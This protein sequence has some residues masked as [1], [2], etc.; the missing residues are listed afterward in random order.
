MTY[1][2]LTSINVCILK[3][4][5]VRV[6]RSIQRLVE[7]CVRLFIV[8]LHSAFGRISY[9]TVFRRVVNL[10]LLDQFW[11]DRRGTIIVLHQ[12]SGCSGLHCARLNLLQI[13]RCA[14]HI[15]QLALVVFQG[16]VPPKGSILAGLVKSAEA[17]VR[18]F[19]SWVTIFGFK[20]GTK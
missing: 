2:L 18:P 12:G 11:L 13:L 8:N 7:W 16:S 3:M 17:G 4:V 1:W 19:C 20:W 14:I 10:A 6:S 15:R 5:F 9:C